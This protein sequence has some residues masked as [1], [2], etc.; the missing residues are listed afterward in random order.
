MKN[1]LIAFLF[2]F[3]LDCIAQDSTNQ[4][5]FKFQDNYIASAPSLYLKC[6]NDIYFTIS[7]DTDLKKVKYQVKGG[8]IIV[9]DFTTHIVLI[10]NAAKVTLE[11]LYDGKMIVK[12]NF[13]VK[14]IPKPVIKVKELSD[15][16]LTEFPQ[17]INIT[18]STDE[19]FEKELPND[20]NYEIKEYRVSLAMRNQLITD[21]IFTK[22]NKEFTEEE[23]KKYTELIKTQPNEDWRL[24]VEVRLLQRINF[25][26]EREN[27]NCF[28]I[29]T[30][31]IKLK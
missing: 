29:F 20:S 31:P 19:A 18:I 1:I 10:P 5:N 23:V 14:L 22:E 15:K 3:S 21:K 12:Q 26:E 24:V 27:I 28:E 17:K 30:L 9:K 8:N 7:E 13:K 11:V 2:L 6:G 4:I 16:T 25:R